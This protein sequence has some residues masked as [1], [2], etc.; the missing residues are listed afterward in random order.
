VWQVNCSC[1]KK[2]SSFIT[3]GTINSDIYIKECVKKRPQML[4]KSHNV[5]PLFWTDFASGHYAM[6]TLDAVAELN[7]EMVSV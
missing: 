2:S 3:F 7:I 1:A 4:V 5:A 6:K